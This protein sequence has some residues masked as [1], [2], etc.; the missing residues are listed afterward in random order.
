[1]DP[2]QERGDKMSPL[3]GE[4]RINRSMDPAVDGDVIQD[5]NF[6]IRR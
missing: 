1:M 5:L 4:N 3:L 2:Y 6:P